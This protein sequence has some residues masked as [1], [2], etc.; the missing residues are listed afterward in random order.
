[1]KDIELSNAS[2]KKKIPDT[3]Q[4]AA[5]VGVGGEL[6][7]ALSVLFRQICCHGGMSRIRVGRMSCLEEE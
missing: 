6:L 4:S 5:A 2:Q 1:M 3:L 7:T